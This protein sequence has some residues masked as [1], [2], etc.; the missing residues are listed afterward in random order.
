MVREYKG[1]N[2]RKNL[3]YF[4]L[5]LEFMH[6][7]CSL[8]EYC[9]KRQIERT[10]MRYVLKFIE[11]K[12]D[13]GTVESFINEA[14]RMLNDFLKGREVF[15]TLQEEDVLILNREFCSVKTVISQFSSVLNRV[16]SAH[17]KQQQELMRP[18]F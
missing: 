3:D 8:R 12:L 16:S 11:E 4:I 17:R 6:Q 5:A 13:R 14:I 15:L 9:R 2:N 7:Q 1:K 10:R 18:R